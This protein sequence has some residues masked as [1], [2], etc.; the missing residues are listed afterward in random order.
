MTY[1]IRVHSNLICGNT[2]SLLGNDSLQTLKSLEG[3]IHGQLLELGIDFVVC[4]TQ[5]KFLSQLEELV[6]D[7]VDLS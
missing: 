2:F 3:H 4:G 5:L 6:I 7:L 1:C